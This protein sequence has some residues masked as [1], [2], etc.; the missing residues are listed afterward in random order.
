MKKR[1]IYINV[2]LFGVLFLLTIV[3]KLFN[4]EGYG[5]LLSYFACPSEFSELLL[6]PW[7]FITY[8]FT[9]NDLINALFNMLWLYWI[10]EMFY[11]VYSSR[12]LVSMY[13]FGGLCGAFMFMFSYA[14]FP[15]LREMA[16]VHFLLGASASVLSLMG[17]LL[18]KIPN[19]EL[20]L[21]LFG[22][23]RFKWVALAFIAIDVLLLL[24]APGR[25]FAHI[26]G[27]LSGVLFAWQF[28]KGRDVTRWIN[29]VIDW[30]ATVLR[31]VVGFVKSL[32][33]R[34]WRHNPKMK[35]HYRDSGKS[36]DYDYNLRRKA[37]Q[38][39]IDRILDKIKRDGYTSLTADEKR[40]LFD[41]G[42]K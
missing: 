37:E 13:V 42:R 40:R 30:C 21:F 27:F 20:R 2:V 23:V 8:M 39:E 5:R 12:Q 36:A 34:N 4:I 33:K 41:A 11:Q 10:G 3:Y 15:Y 14:F 31:P 22:R 25:H 24:D 17:A 19:Y 26:G 18:Y 9:D 32:G 35:V 1:L 28:D 38:D 6:R 16:G 29:V 7:T